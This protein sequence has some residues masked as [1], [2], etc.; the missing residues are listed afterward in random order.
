MTGSNC[1]CGAFITEEHGV[2][3]IYSDH[4]NGEEEKIERISPDFRW[5]RCSPKHREMSEDTGDGD[6]GHM[7]HTLDA[8]SER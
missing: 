7:H 8:S 1:R 4:R 2:P 6:L 5:A 3:A